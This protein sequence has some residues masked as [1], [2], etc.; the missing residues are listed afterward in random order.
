[1]FWELLDP[2]RAVGVTTALSHSPV[3]ICIAGLSRRP[4]KGV[5]VGVKTGMT[6]DHIVRHSVSL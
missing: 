5:K 3:H 4:R 1:M 6:N 2:W